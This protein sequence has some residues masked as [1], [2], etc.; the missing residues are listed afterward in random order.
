MKYRSSFILLTQEIQ[1]ALYD[2]V[3]LAKNEINSEEPLHIYLPNGQERRLRM[4]KQLKY[5]KAYKKNGLTDRTIQDTL[6]IGY[7]IKVDKE[8]LHRFFSMSD[9]LKKSN[10]YEAERKFYILQKSKNDKK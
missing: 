10:F 4:L 5:V 2:E 1:S 6:L 7:D 3:T 9:L 8:A